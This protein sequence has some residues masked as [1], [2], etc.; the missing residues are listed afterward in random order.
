MIDTTKEGVVP[1]D[2]QSVE[3]SGSTEEV[4]RKELWDTGG[5]RW[6]VEDGVRLPSKEGDLRVLLKSFG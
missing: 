5:G 1:N 6:T 2:S 3:S 4:F